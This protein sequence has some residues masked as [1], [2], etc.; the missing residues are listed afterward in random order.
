MKKGRP[1][2]VDY[3]PEEFEKLSRE[4]RQLRGRLSTLKRIIM[5]RESKMDELMKPVLKLKEEINKYEKEMNELKNSIKNMG[6]NFPTFRVE[7][8]TIMKNDKI[9]HYYRG[10]WYVKGKKKQKYL[11][12]E[13]T[14]FSVV[15]KKYKGFDKLT[16]SE[17]ESKIYEYYLPEF[18]LDYWKK[19]YEEISNK[20][21]P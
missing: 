1:K 11:G 14:V 13:N 7:S 8:F 21:T 17:K 10:V 6:F 12:S 15:G 2:S 5:R 9:H 16:T 18:Q 4:E 19:E 3:T 20:K